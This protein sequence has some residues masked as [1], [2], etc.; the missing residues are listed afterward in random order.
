MRGLHP[1]AVALGLAGVLPFIACGLAALD[2]GAGLAGAGFAALLGY[3]AVI[4]SFLGGV[5]WGL[6]LQE[7]P[8]G[9]PAGTRY[10]GRRLLLGTLPALAGWAALLVARSVSGELGLGLLIGGFLATLAAEARG[11]RLGLVP[12]GYMWL[13][14]IL[15]TVVIAVLVTVLVLRLAG[16]H[17]YF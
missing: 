14:W 11:R 4:L 9:H 7:P 3:G 6:V 17:V 8:P 13:R 1:L 12:A 5:H 2:A 15:G 10:D 16:A